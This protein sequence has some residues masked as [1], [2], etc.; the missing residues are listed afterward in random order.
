MLRTPP[1]HI[2]EEKIEITKKAVAAI[3]RH[4]ENG[5]LILDQDNHPILKVKLDFQNGFLEYRQFDSENCCVF[6]NFDKDYDD[7]FYNSLAWVKNWF[8]KI[9]VIPKTKCKL[10]Y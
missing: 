7:G 9:K 1:K 3:Q 2:Q 5:D 6:F 8:S 4:L 10:K